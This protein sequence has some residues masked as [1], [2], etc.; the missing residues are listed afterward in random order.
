MDI[1][2]AER[3]IKAARQLL[4]PAQSPTPAPAPVD[5]AAVCRA[6]AARLPGA[7]GSFKGRVPPE[8]EEALAGLPVLF[9]AV[10][11]L[12]GE[13]SDSA[14]I[15]D[16][17]A[18]AEGVAKMLG[19]RAVVDPAL[20]PWAEDAGKAARI[21]NAL[22]EGEEGHWPSLPPLLGRGAGLA[23]MLAG[24]AHG[25]ELVREQLSTRED[26][27][28]RHF[29]VLPAREG[30][31]A[32]RIVVTSLDGAHAHAIPT[33]DAATTEENGMHSHHVIVDGED[34]YTDEGE[35]HRHALLGGSMLPGSGAHQ[36]GL[37]LPWGAVRSLTPE[38]AW[39]WCRAAQTEEVEQTPDAGAPMT[40]DAACERARRE[41]AVAVWRAEPPRGTL[42]VLKLPAPAFNLDRLRS[43]QPTGFL[44]RVRRV[45]RVGKPQALVNEV[46]DGGGTF[47]W[48]VVEQGEPEPYVGIEALPEAVLA[49]IDK[50]SLEEFAAVRGFFHMPLR[51]L[52]EFDPPLRLLAPLPGRR[53]GPDIELSTAVARARQL[54]LPFAKV[55]RDG[56]EAQLDALV[57]GPSDEALAALSDE[58][59]RVLDRAMHAWFADA[60][61]TGIAEADG[62]S[63]E[64]VINAHAFLL[65]EMARREISMPEDDQLAQET[66]TWKQAATGE[67]A[68]IHAGS[69]GALEPVSLPDVLACYDKPMRLRD[70][71]VC[72]VG[73]LCNDGVSKNDIDVLVRGPLDEDTLHVVK[74]RL[75]RALPPDLSRR[76]SYH[77]DPMGGPFTSFVKL[78]DLV[79]VP[80][81]D[82]SLKQMALATK[83]DD[84]M[85]DWP[86][87][88]GPRPGVLQLHFRGRSVHGDLRV[89]VGDY[90]VG[91]TLMLQRP[92]VVPDVDTLEAARDVAADFG[93]EGSRYTK[94]FRLPERIMAAPKSRQPKGW[95]DV[96]GEVFGEGEIGATRYERGVM[97]AVAHPTVEWGL[98]K[99]YSHEYFLTGDERFSGRLV[100]RA[101][102]G[103]RALDEEEGGPV[104]PG[105]PAGEVFWTV[106]FARNALPS[107]LDRRSV[108]RRVMP[109]PG[110]SGMPESLMAATPAE[111]RYWEEPDQARAR[112]VRDALVAARL[113]TADTVAVEAG[114]FVLKGS[115]PRTKATLVD[116]TI[117]GSPAGKKKLAERLVALLPAHKTYVEPFAGS[118]AVLFA[119]D[120][121]ETEVINDADPEIV[122]A[123]RLIKRLKPEQVARLRKMTWTGDE[124]T[125]KRLFDARPK[126][127][128]EKL[129]RFLYVTHF[130]YRKLRGRSFSPSGEGIEAATVDRIEKFGPRLKNVRIHCGDYERVVR[131]YDGKDTAFYL[132]P[133]YPGYNVDVGESDFDEARFLALLKSIK[134]KFL[135]TYGTRGELPARFEKEGF[136]VKR[137]RP[138]R[139]I[140]SMRGVGGPKV[141]T[142]LLVSNYDL[143][144]K[145]LTEALGDDWTLNDAALVEA[146]KVALPVRV[147]YTLSWQRF[148]G[149]TVVR[150]VGREVFH[151]IIGRPEGGLWNYQLQ[152]DPLASDAQVLA[153]RHAAVNDELLALSGDVPPG[154]VVGTI[155]LNP[156]RATPSRLTIQER[157]DA[158][159]LEHEP[160]SRLL[161]RFGGPKL[162]G[163]YEFRAEEPGGA[164]W[165]M[166]PQAPAE[167]DAATKRLR[168]DGEVQ[169]WD[170]A[171]RTEG[172]DRGGDRELLRPPA[173]FTPTKPAPRRTAAF[174][175]AESAAREAF[176]DE[177]V[178]A[179]VQVEPKLNG[180]RV[181][182][183]RWGEHGAMAFTE[184]SPEENILARW[185]SLEREVLALPGDLILDGEVMEWDADAG[186]YKPRREL[187]DLRGMEPDDRGLR[188]VVFDALYL[189]DQKNLTTAPLS[190]RRA[191]L[192]GWIERHKAQLQHICLDEFRVVADRP[193]LR[194][195]I[196]WAARQPGSE[197]AM[198]KAIGS[199]LSLG[200]ENDLWAKVKLVRELRAL[201]V[202]RHEVAGSP[203][204]Y[205]F[206]GA[207][208]PVRPEDGAWEGT[209]ERDGKSWVVIG[210]TGNRRLAA[211]VGDVIRVYSL[212]FLHRS[213]EPRSVSWFGPAQAIDVVDGPPSTI[214]EVLGLLR[215]GESMPGSLAK[216]ERPVR[217]LKAE[218]PTPETEERYVFGVVLVP[219]EVDAQGDIYDAATVRKAA[220][221]FL[222]HFGGHMRIMHAGKPLDGIKVLESYVSKVT[223]SHGGEDFPV[224]TWFLATR[225]GPD[226]VWEQVKNGSLDGYSIGGT[227][228]K[229]A[230]RAARSK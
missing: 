30:E 167:A 199:T 183:Q 88:P 31:A 52:V 168:M 71:A 174:S 32:P 98:Q 99:P 67:F 42:P 153:V 182:L 53:F 59:L 78:Y 63:R 28:H 29:F 40:L 159:L 105:V 123:Y 85:L 227:A 140:G 119:K 93:A 83:A 213:L 122:E 91:W 43:G 121:A 165:T 126:D 92:D 192:N 207:I 73:S 112:A 219:D 195:A 181:V 208:G 180:F 49:G 170:P 117:W 184:D 169:V 45:G 9:S 14:Q 33:H 224:G 20:A 187:A 79:L 143:V 5:V 100:F 145:S 86:R 68:P 203:G 166:G 178:A 201:V 155:A 229:E 152:T 41:G 217:L 44:S 38:Q 107:V 147:P 90:L 196:D 158:E 173:R 81:E 57:A 19:E 135:V 194:D 17:G 141:L 138:S 96:E 197:G 60:F 80:H 24:G 18:A 4:T 185:P 188:F 209:V 1:E 8:A 82:R 12:S 113:F 116:K 72:L 225:A 108:E 101:L 118:G 50:P 177:L 176:T 151:V 111:Y 202:E 109:P 114:Q 27:A 191:A 146:E 218:Q 47:V 89:D 87:E 230:L 215:A 228:V 129:H 21:I 37:A 127:D 23:R 200:G 95:L 133:P 48:A 125:F 149:Q 106:G 77:H 76:V 189:P 13:S 130:S 36:H 206:V 204:V 210:T 110:R 10:E 84:P 58:D 160:G 139:T 94:P 34:H 7:L 226:E 137:I 212:E 51:L 171:E 39:P 172:D 104:A 103:D 136:R 56:V 62:A 162:Q 142:T 15:D 132:D 148:K 46:P 163:T 2:R 64:Q 198:L 124:A 161:V 69:N 154:T 144:E 134:G 26:G 66:A 115:E 61:P 54:G 193:S 22:L 70:A 221:A 220:H 102:V 131:K 150:G 205:N 216:A 65:R 179:G 75:G 222:E 120:P 223:E 157:G 175:D 186:A 35:P 97:V 214:P 74:F 11:K 211:D 190:V 6:L 164:I 3:A 16:I 55:F 156:T 25:H 128:V